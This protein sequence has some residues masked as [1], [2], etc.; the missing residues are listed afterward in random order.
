MPNLLP[1][2][3]Y[4]LGSLGGR[5][6]RRRLPPPSPPPLSAPYEEPLPQAEMYS[7]LTPQVAP[8]DAPT[9]PEDEGR[10]LAEYLA[11]TKQA[12]MPERLSG[13][14]YR[15]GED[16]YRP[17]RFQRLAGA[18]ATGWMG[19]IGGPKAAQ[20]T[21]ESIFEKPY[22][23]EMGE[24]G[25]R[26]EM[27]RRRV[28]ELQPAMQLE[29]QR[30][31]RLQIAEENRGGRAT[32][33]M[34]RRLESADT[35]ADRMGVREQAAKDRAAALAAKETE[36]Y[37]LG[38]GQRRFKGSQVI[39]E[40]V[41]LKETAVKDEYEKA[42]AEG[43]KGS[44]ADWKTLVA[45]T[46]AT[47]W[48]A[49]ATPE[50]KT[51]WVHKSTGEVSEAPPRTRPQFTAT[52]RTQLS[53]FDELI[54]RSDRLRDIADRNRGSIGWLQGKGSALKRN[55]VG[56]SDEVNELFRISDNMADVLLRARSGAQINE[57]EYI[58]L[59]T[60]VPNPR[61]SEAKF[62]SDLELFQQELQRIRARRSGAAPLITP[63]GSQPQSGGGAG[64]Q[65]GGAGTIH[66]QSGAKGW[67]IPASQAAEF[68]AAH[69]E[70]KRQ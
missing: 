41:P 7:R 50:G 3:G 10:L 17:S 57:Q 52:E 58:R 60:L 25:A 43:Y 5:F 64:G 49:M 47:G 1:T 19:G 69:P 68:E 37:T 48:I 65:G 67:D 12:P 35:R 39:A 61:L 34:R 15:V 13:G 54:G 23:R 2:Q 26:E 36:P 53:D 11:A 44:R 18:A 9:Q 30:K 56:V 40:G 29:E 21:H 46:Y 51:I 31:T 32:E 22:E 59:R 24:Y 14:G 20:E 4:R 55:I 6:N 27:R 16:T 42:V 70:A 66:Y 8:P 62:F 38:P 63:T 28:A 45:D 33:A